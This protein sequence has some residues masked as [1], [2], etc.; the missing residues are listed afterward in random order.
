MSGCNAMLTMYT[1]LF[2][3]VD[4]FLPSYWCSAGLP[5]SP[6]YVCA[7]LRSTWQAGFIYIL[8]TTLS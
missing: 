8:V 2:G 5:S 7:C 6:F 1:E 3:I 4:P